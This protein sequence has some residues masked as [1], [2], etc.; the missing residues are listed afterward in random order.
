MRL[1][2]FLYL[3][4]V[5]AL[6]LVACAKDNE[7]SP[8]GLRLRQIVTH[9]FMPDS[10]EYRTLTYDTQGRVSVI[11]DSVYK[12]F[13]FKY[14]YSYDSKGQLSARTTESFFDTKRNSLGRFT[15]SF[16]YDANNRISK[17][18]LLSTAVRSYEIVQFYLYDTQNR[19]VADSVN[20][21]TPNT[22][23]T[24]IT[25][26]SYDAN[27][28]VIQQEFLHY[29]NGVL[30]SN[31]VFQLSYTAQP[32][33]YKSLGFDSYRFP[34]NEDIDAF[35][36]S[37]HAPQ[38]VRLTND[39]GVTF[40]YDYNNDR[41]VSKVVRTYYHPTMQSVQLTTELFYQ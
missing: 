18:L 16:V 38:Q 9:D 11:E 30:Q 6:L 17:R 21:V 4:V 26:F 31:M 1:I 34:L 41:T 7:P 25:K 24:S 23:S 32:N 36:L 3:F 35:K 15:D 12:S 19:L 10:T 22:T 28:D 29:S 37:K 40:Q 5:A 20:I 27:E 39:T 13:I 14:L 33:P 2:L 8:S